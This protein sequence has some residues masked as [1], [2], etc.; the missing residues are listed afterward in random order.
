MGAMEKLYVICTFLGTFL[1]V[2][3]FASYYLEADA[4]DATLVRKPGGVEAKVS[5]G[6]HPKGRSS[7]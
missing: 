7:P 2:L 6:R 4:E 3:L 5:S 1:F